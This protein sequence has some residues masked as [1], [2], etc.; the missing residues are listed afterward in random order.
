[1]FLVEHLF[2]CFSYEIKVQRNV[3]KDWPY[4]ALKSWPPYVC[5]FIAFVF[6][7]CIV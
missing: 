3:I 4:Y 7:R 5:I 2:S 1:V 6:L